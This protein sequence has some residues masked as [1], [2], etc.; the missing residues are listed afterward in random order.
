MDTMQS[1][2]H[3]KGE[4]VMQYK[5]AVPPGRYLPQQCLYLFGR[6][7]G[8][9][10]MQKVRIPLTQMADNTV[11]LTVKECGLCYDYGC[12]HLYLIIGCGFPCLCYGRPNKS[13]EASQSFHTGSRPSCFRR[14]FISTAVRPSDTVNCSSA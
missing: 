11:C 3:R 13:N 7:T 8:L 2:S 1:V 14:L 9:A 4:M 5:A 10:D 6:G 12:K